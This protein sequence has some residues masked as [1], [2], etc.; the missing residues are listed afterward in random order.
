M[1]SSRR[2]SSPAVF[3]LPP[4]YAVV[5]RQPDLSRYSELVESLSPP[6]RAFI[7]N[8]TRLLNSGADG[9]RYADAKAVT[10]NVSSNDPDLEHLQRQVDDAERQNRQ[11]TNPQG[12]AKA[13]V[14]RIFLTMVVLLALPAVFTALAAIPSSFPYSDKCSDKRQ[15]KVKGTAIYFGIALGWLLVWSLL[16]TWKHKG[17]NRPRGPRAK[18]S[19]FWTCFIWIGYC[20]VVAFIWVRNVCMWL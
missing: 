15:A 1:S 14:W 16:R 19:V 17:R 6:E 5:S 12:N 8:Q 18:S 9:F 7:A 3:S 10:S 13:N 2:I 20:V 4:S 11:A